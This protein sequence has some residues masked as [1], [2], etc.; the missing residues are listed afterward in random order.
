MRYAFIYK[1]YHPPTRPNS[2][3]AYRITLGARLLRQRKFL[4]S[5]LTFTIHNFCVAKIVRFTSRHDFFNFIKL[6]QILRYAIVE[7]IT[8][9]TGGIH[10]IS[11]EELGN[12]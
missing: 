12:K 2:L 11:S 9:E 7:V 4:L 5:F 3:Y 6:S 1:E 10:L 8:S